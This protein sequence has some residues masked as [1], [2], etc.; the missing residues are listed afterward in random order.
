MAVSDLDK[1]K[2]FTQ[3]K[4]SLGAPIRDI[5]LLDEMLC[6][7]LQIA[8]ED[9]SMHVQNWLIEHQWQSLLG[10]NID[11]T[12]MAFAMSVRDFDFVTQY[13]YAYSKQVGLR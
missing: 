7:F 13:T 8:T 6:T 1:E 4:H 5:E 2:I 10:K 9:Y 12:D 3:F 11:T